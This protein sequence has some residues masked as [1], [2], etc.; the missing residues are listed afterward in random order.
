MR[1]GKAAARLEKIRDTAAQ[2]FANAGYAPLDPPIFAPADTFLDRLG[3]QFRRQTC[4]FEDGTGQE[5]CLRP[6]ITIPVCRMALEEGFDG[7][8]PLRLRYCGTV[9]RLAQGGAGGLIQSLQAGVELLGE[10]NAAEAD[11]EIIKLCLTAVEA[12]GLSGCRVTLGDAGAFADL[13]AGLALSDRQRAHVR[14]LFDAYGSALSERLPQE[15]AAVQPRVL[16]FD[17]ALA[18]TEAEL[19]AQSLVITGGRTAEDIARRLADRAGRE[20]AS[21]VP[22]TARDALARF[23]ALSAPVQQAAE[24]LTAFFDSVGVASSAPGRLH[25]LAHALA[26]QGL[27]LQNIG[28][29]ASVHAPLGYY[30]G[31]EFRVECGDRNIAGGGRYDSLMGELADRRGWRIP[32]VGCALFLDE[33]VMESAP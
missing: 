2:A 24:L 22:A 28:F 14:T 8:T 9:F 10:P 6:E 21:A 11:A 3:E 5:L 32:A 17:L 13:I 25:S 26:A 12:Q 15:A 19:E 23:F 16:D 1:S 27:P 4:F 29:D 7:T 31:L 20:Q 33:I 30:T 18:Q